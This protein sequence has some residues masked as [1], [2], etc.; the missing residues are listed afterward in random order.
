[1]KKS[2]FVFIQALLIACN[3]FAGAN[4]EKKTQ[5]LV[6]GT[7][8]G[9]APYVSLNAKGEY[10]G[11]DIDLARLLS[12]KLGREIVIQDF[13]SMPSLMMAL[14]QDKADML[15]WAISI[16]K[17]RLEK[18]EMIYYQGE[19]LDRA[20]FLFWEKVPEGISSI[21]DLEKIPNAVLCVEAGSSQ[22]AILKAFPKLHLKYAD[23]VLDSVIDL[24]YGKSL[25]TTI[26]PGL[27]AGYQK[28]Y[29]QLQVAYLQIPEDQKI[30]GNGIAISKKNQKL[31][32]EVKEAVS[33]LIAEGKIA[34]I[35]KKWN[36]QE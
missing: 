28:K 25:S 33:E 1:M 5:P 6:V 21:S 19:T 24:K 30:F 32:S 4:T 27:I 10:E 35:E 23:K 36:L 26:D 11:F 20:P 13:G 16:T 2:F 18:I 9:Y 31:A 14:K 3:A 17:E 8:T 15:I 7:T 22:E 12:E 29:P 34:Q